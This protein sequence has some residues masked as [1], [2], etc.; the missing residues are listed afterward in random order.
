MGTGTD[1][2]IAERGRHPREGRPRAASCA[3]AA[4][5]ARRSRTSGRT[6]SGRS[7]TTRSAIPVAAGAL[8]PLLGWLLSPMLAAAAMSL[9][10]VTVITNALRLRRAGC[11]GGDGARAVRAGRLD[12]ARRRASI[13]GDDETRA[14]AR[15]GGGGPGPRGHAAARLPVRRARPATRPVARPRT[16]AAH[17]RPASRPSTRAAAAVPRRPVPDSLAAAAPAA[18]P[19]PAVASWRSW[20]RP[21][22]LRRDSPPVRAPL[23]GARLAS[24]RPAHL[25]LADA[26]RPVSS[27]LVSSVGPALLKSRSAAVRIAL[28]PCRLMMPRLPMPFRPS[29]RSR[30]RPLAVLAFA[31]GL[32]C[33]P[34][35]A[36][37]AAAPV[38][39]A[40][41]PVLQSLVQ[42]AL[43]GSPLL[44]QAEEEL[45]GARQRPGQARALADPMLSLNYTN[46][47]WKPTLGS[48]PMTTLGLMGSQNLPYAGQAP[49]ARG[50]RREGGRPVRPAP[51][52][53]AARR[54]GRGQGVL[55]GPPRGSRPRST[56]WRP[57]KGCCVRST[58]S[59]ARATPWGRAPS[60]T[61][62]RVQIEMT[63]LEQRRAERVA[64]EAV[65]LAELNALAGRPAGTPVETR[66]GSC[67][68]R[69]R[70]RSMAPW[71]TRG[72]RAP[73]WRTPGS[74]STPPASA[75][76]WPSATTSRTSVSPP[77]T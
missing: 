14:A 71:P 59:S 10:S 28:S 56:S 4:S 45:A 70:P 64:D 32:L 42:E 1:V 3:R 35:R 6:S 36:Q 29:P 12:D 63:R 52:A 17:R 51:R 5:R 50:H 66:R 55:R 46:D 24:T 76:P 43:A 65:R 18:P 31:A 48:E 19:P 57:T 47:G 34:V 22:S 21:R 61:C 26:G 49:A 41:D 68:A 16:T 73:S 27:H 8:Y 53:G 9:S 13:G 60:P 23:A 69:C 40:A 7:P 20:H 75:S 44:K 25:I 38:P 67:A 39:P 62:I 77:D 72:S 30:V 37:E 74:R 58:V 15:G 11:S 33:P 2:A 54:G